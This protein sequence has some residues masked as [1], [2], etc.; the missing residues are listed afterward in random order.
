MSSPFLTLSS[1]SVKVGESTLLEDID[2]TV[3]SGELLFILGSNGAGKTTLLRAVLGLV[4]YSGTIIFEQR[5]IRELS[6]RSLAS[7]IAYV[8]QGVELKVSYSVRQFT[9]LS[10]YPLGT[11]DAERFAASEEALRMANC[12]EIADRPIAELSGGERQRALIAGALAQKP[13]LL[14]IDEPMTYL[15]PRQQREIG[16]LLGFLSKEKGIAVLAVTHEINFARELPARFF[17]LKQ[18]KQFGSGP[19]ETL[20]SVGMFEKIYDLQAQ[21]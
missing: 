6:R 15:D 17:A 18:G 9:E 3:S 7:C 5:D 20:R 19:I 12:L 4:P 10:G 21:S 11:S 13:K 2:L 16:A 1:V 8:P 14:L